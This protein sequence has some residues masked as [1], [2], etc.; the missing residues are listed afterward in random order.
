MIYLDVEALV[1]LADP[2]VV[3]CDLDGTWIEAPDDEAYELVIGVAEGR[4][5]VPEIARSLQCWARP[6]GTGP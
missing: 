1:Q 3:F 5:D 4:L 6:A 2:A